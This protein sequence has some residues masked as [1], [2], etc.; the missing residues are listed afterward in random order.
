MNTNDTAKSFF[1]MFNPLENDL[2][3]E[4]EAKVKELEAH[5]AGAG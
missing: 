1:D 2:A 3:H 5:Q 4:H